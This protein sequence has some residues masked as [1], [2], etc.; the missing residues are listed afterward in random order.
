MTRDEFNNRFRAYKRQWL[1]IETDGLIVV[2]LFTLAAFLL[3]PH[4][5]HLCFEEPHRQ[6]RER[7]AALASAT[8]GATLAAF[9]ALMLVLVWWCRRCTPRSFGLLCPSCGAPLT[10]T[11]RKA[12][13]NTGECGRCHGR[14]LDDGG[15]P[16]PRAL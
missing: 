13:L 9:G 12:L 15:G 1:R 7:F 14:I 8:L 11:N 4:L 2:A 3:F 6:E 5:V 16:P 10:G